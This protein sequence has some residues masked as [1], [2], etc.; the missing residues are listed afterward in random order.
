MVKS[1]RQVEMFESI[2]ASA[3]IEVIL[4][5]D[6]VVKV[7]VEADDNL[8]EIIK[9]EVSNGTL[10]IFPEQPI[11]SCTAKRV[12]V[13]IKTI[14]SLEVSS[15]SE[16]KSQSE[17]KMPSL[18]LSASSGAKVDLALAVDRLGVEASS[19]GNIGLSGSAENLDVDGSSGA[20]INASGLQSKTCNAG[21]SSGAS[22]K[23][24]VSEKIVAK[25]SS[26]GNVRVEGNPKDRNISKSSGGEV[27]FR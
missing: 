13:T 5:Q 2:K 3:G 24:Y 20:N 25:T 1:E 11:R 7:V 6:S 21:A 4:S 15:G 23:I 8:Q 26:G 18:G 17:L 10:K 27:S 9:T 12:Y 16:V 19:G 14:H 22:L